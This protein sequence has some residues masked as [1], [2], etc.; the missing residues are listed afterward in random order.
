VDSKDY[1]FA[2]KDTAEM[3]ASLGSNKH[4][5]KRQLSFRSCS[6]ITATERLGACRATEKPYYNLNFNTNPIILFI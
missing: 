3:L 5:S 6:I 2:R 1:V 4:K